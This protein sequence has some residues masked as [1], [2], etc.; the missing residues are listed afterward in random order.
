M[1]FLFYIF[2]ISVAISCS[3]RNATDILSFKQGTFKTYLKDS[4]DSSTFVRT[5]NL[6]IEHYKQKVDTFTVEWIHNFEYHLKKLHPNSKLD[7]IPF[8][9]KITGIKENSY[10]F[11]G[12][13]QGSNFKQEG[14]SHKL[15]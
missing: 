12:H 13:Y 2:S 10:K 15:K 11:K 1:K 3:S 9:V 14:T 7:S 6:Q 8:I 4:K 5:K